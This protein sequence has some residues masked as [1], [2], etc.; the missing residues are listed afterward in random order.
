[1]IVSE[2][3]PILILVLIAVLAI[4][5][6]VIQGIR[7]QK[8]LILDS[9]SDIFD[10]LV[11]KKKRQINANLGGLSWRNY[12]LL[13]VICPIALA[14]IGF[15]LLDNKSVCIVLAFV[16]ILIPEIILRITAKQ[17]KK[18]FE[19]NYA[20]ALRAL[21]SGLRSGLTIEQA[22]DNVGRNPFLEVGI[23][24]GFKQIATDIKFGI[25]MD[26][27]FQ[28]FANDSESQDA[29]DVAN[30][31]SMQAKVGGSEAAVITTIVQ[32][33]NDRIMMRNEIQALFASTNMLVTVMDF[34]PIVLVGM[35]YFGAYDLL[36]PYFESPSMTM[37]L[38]GLLAF[39]VAGSLII[40]K[41]ASSA[42]GR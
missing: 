16:G 13:M 17:Q 7:S 10:E 38:V 33:I 11:D 23:R 2:I 36:E 31:L 39:S 41:M 21:A 20:M 35:L 27:A 37:V 25:P 1:M 19:E 22:I 6:I 3:L 24:D 40:H 28:N 42:K 30:A 8:S 9:D 12:V 32:N 15:V 14:G 5:F 4:T 18:K 34:M 29:Q 26:E